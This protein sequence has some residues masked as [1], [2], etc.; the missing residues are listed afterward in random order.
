VAMDRVAFVACAERAADRVLTERDHALWAEIMDTAWRI[1]RFAVDFFWSH[2]RACGCVVGE[3]IYRREGSPPR[4]QFESRDIEDL[5]YYQPL[6]DAFG[7]RMDEEVR[8]AAGVSDEPVKYGRVPDI[9]VVV[10][11]PQ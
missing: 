10:D 9:V 3:L 11:G 8:A 7:R 4:G 6:L 2:E 1:N 5:R